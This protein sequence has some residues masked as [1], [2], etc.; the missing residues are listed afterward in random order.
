M[1]FYDKYPVATS[2]LLHYPLIFPET[3]KEYHIPGIPYVSLDFLY[4]FG[5]NFGISQGAIRTNLSRMKK[6]GFVL[7]AS[8]D[9][10]IRYRTSAL[11]R[12][13]MQ[14]ILKRKKKRNQGYKIAV[15]SFERAQEKK[16]SEVRALLEYVGF[17]RFAQNAF[18]NVGIDVRELRIK[19]DQADVGSNVYIF[20]VPSVDEKDAIR[21]AA[22]WNIPERAS[23][24][25][26]FLADLTSFLGALD[27]S[28]EEAFNKIGYAWIAY[29]AHIAGSEPPVPEELLPDDYAYNDIYEFLHKTSI[30]YGKQMLK[31]YKDNNR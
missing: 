5:A 30:R 11:Q 27:D 6:E 20:D 10:T 31:H 19:L 4:Q 2:E 28:D 7:S 16:R 23:F 9:S 13:T 14:N 18:I 12:E 21:L 3:F 22:A 29:T 24:L 25:S 15:Y 17:V 1:S 26:E 8:K